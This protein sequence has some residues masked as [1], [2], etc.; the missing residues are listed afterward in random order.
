MY[1]VILVPAGCCQSTLD[2]GVMEQHANKMHQQ[3]YDL[4]HV[5]QSATASCMFGSKTAAVMVFKQR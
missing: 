3:G 1:K 5:Y 4:A 2:V